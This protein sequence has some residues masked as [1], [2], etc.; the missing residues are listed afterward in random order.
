MSRLESEPT[1]TGIT[2]NMIGRDCSEAENLLHCVKSEEGCVAAEWS[3][4]TTAP[5]IPPL[6]IEDNRSMWRSLIVRHPDAIILSPLK[7]KDT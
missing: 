4:L 3:P 7:E 6:L 1:I 5:P 2:A